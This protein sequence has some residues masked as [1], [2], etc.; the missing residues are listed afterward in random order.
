MAESQIRQLRLVNGRVE[1]GTN[2]N[3][4]YE[5]KT[6]TD[7]EHSSCDEAEAEALE[8]ADE[9]ED[10]RT[11]EDEIF[12]ENESSAIMK[13][14]MLNEFDR[15]YSQSKAAERKKNSPAPLASCEDQY[16]SQSW[17][18]ALEM[19]GCFK[20]EA[21]ANYRIPSVIPMLFYYS[22]QM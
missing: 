19:I 2:G 22:I 12:V 9:C 16:E 3:G 5:T 6:E 17:V 1:C 7:S 8:A 4:T 11:E 14:L 20:K 10:S 21:V 13:K 18:M 15:D